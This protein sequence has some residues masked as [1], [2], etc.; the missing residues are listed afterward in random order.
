M[1]PISI[2]VNAGT[3][4]TFRMTGK[5]NGISVRKMFSLIIP[6]RTGIARTGNEKEFQ[7]QPPLC[8]Q[9]SLKGFISPVDPPLVPQS[10]ASLNPFN[11]NVYI[12]IL[13]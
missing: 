4:L 9:C 12:P 2:F 6:A 1:H 11:C 5:A 3:R 13:G 8:L 7:L 10:S